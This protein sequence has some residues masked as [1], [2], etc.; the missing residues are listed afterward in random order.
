MHPAIKALARDK[1]GTNI[2]TQT[3]VMKYVTQICQSII[4][5]LYFNK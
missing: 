5:I 1:Q 2:D 3:D 4:T